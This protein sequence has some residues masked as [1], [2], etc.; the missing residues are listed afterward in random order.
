M[1]TIQCA[2]CGSDYE[3]KR[4]NTKY[5]RACRLYRD[6]TFIQDRTKECIE[7][8]RKFAPVTRKDLVCGSCFSHMAQ[9]HA[10]HCALCDRDTQHLIHGDVACCWSCATDPKK[11]ITLLRALAKRRRRSEGR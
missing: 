11:R 6:L 4:S 3:T 7:C 2:D 5:C 9:V 8:E 10:G 1:R